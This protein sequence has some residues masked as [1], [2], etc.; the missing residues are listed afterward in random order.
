MVTQISG[1][2]NTVTE[3][4][5]CGSKKEKRPHLPFSSEVNPDAASTFSS[6]FLSFIIFVAHTYP[7]LR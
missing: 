2:D 1:G 3:T 4:Y 6:I 7:Y 5:M